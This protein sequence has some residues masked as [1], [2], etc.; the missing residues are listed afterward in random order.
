MDFIPN[1]LSVPIPYLYLNSTAVPELPRIVPGS[2]EHPTLSELMGMV[3]MAR[4]RKCIV[5]H[6]LTS[7]PTDNECCSEL[8]YRKKRE[9]IRLQEM[10][11]ELIPEEGIL[12]WDLDELIE[13]R[14]Q[15]N[16]WN[17]LTE[18]WRVLEKA[19]QLV[20]NNS[21]IFLNTSQV[22]ADRQAKPGQKRLP[23]KS[24]A[25]MAKEVKEPEMSQKSDSHEQKIAS[26]LAVIDSVGDVDALLR[27]REAVN[28]LNKT[29]T[30]LREAREMVMQLEAQE[31]ACQDIVFDLR[32]RI[33][34]SIK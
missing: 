24:K 27:Y 34:E 12:R 29:R 26:V 5:C 4:G 32:A 10:V 7:K 22:L 23:A 2:G 3:G 18:A 28:N 33:A 30:D 8:C 13:S 15:K 31:L 1:S 9:A 11:R 25:A 20:E 17:K 21:T 6:T 19:G 16:L 14:F